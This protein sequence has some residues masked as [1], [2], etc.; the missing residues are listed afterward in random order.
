VSDLLAIRG[1]DAF[2][3]RQGSYWAPNAALNPF[4]ILL[5]RTTEDVSRAM[6]AV[7]DTGVKFAVRSGGHVQWA[8]GS[9]VA[10]GATIDLGRMLDVT[11]NP[12]TKLASIQPGPRWGDVFA[13]LQ[14]Q[15]VVVTGGRDANV[16]IGGFLTGGGNAYLTG[17]N[18]FG[19]D[20]VANF[21]VVLADGK[22]VNANKTTNPDLW[23][24]LKGGWANYGVVTRFDLETT[25][26][27]ISWGGSR[28]HDKSTTNQIANAF[29][30]FVDRA[31][32][33]PQDQHL[34]LQVYNI[35]ALEDFGMITVTVDTEAVENATAFD[36]ILAIPE[37]INALGF[38]TLGEMA[39]NGID[40]S[41]DRVHWFTLTFKNDVEIVKKSM[42]LHE[43]MVAEL[44]SAIGADVFT[45]QNV[46]QPIP[47]FY[48]DIGQAKGGNMLGLDRLKDNAVLWLGTVAYDDAA[49]DRVAYEKL[50]AY[51]SK[52][53]RFAKERKAD[54]PW[55]YIN[56]SDKTQ[57]PL[58]SYG[59]AN[60]K[61]MKD[62]AAKYDPTGVFQ[63]QMPG[64]FKISSI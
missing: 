27:D 25:E 31:H 5:P 10:D 3:E 32:E 34:V 23:K 19:C 47:S 50:E 64:S 14:P 48:G 21:E 22:V 46:L 51:K 37:E 49:F 29:S 53:E 40:P 45:S 52:L 1:D 36:E 18:G 57:N 56:Y 4:C 59:P 6:K 28:I 61:F 62:V 33:H 44:G 8:G 39:E 2:A 43:E 16:G 42:E 54:V 12:D 35:V 15:G 17:R 20:T 55:R 9:D 38:N 60:T 30:N 11:F 58:K 41:D 24:A 63:K 26:N 13:T 7:K